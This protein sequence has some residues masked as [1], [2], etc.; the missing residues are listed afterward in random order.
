MFA[1]RA[2]LVMG[3]LFFGSAVYADGQDSQGDDLAAFFGAKV[4]FSWGCHGGGYDHDCHVTSTAES[5]P[6]PEPP[7][8]TEL[9]TLD[10]PAGNY[11]LF[12]KLS[13]YPDAPGNY[14]AIYWGGLECF[15][16]LADRSQGDWTTTGFSEDQ[17]VQVNMA[18]VMLTARHNKVILGCRL[19]GMWYWEWEGYESR[20]QVKV[21][22]WGARL[23]AVRVGSVVEQPCH[24]QCQ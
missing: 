23:M 2:L 19:Q 12:G 10:L 9:A 8:Y 1:G 11:L 4:Y 14:P 7:V 5:W 24:T 20:Q 15:A 3:L 21:G 6:W 13:T 22:I 18:P 17:N 16:G